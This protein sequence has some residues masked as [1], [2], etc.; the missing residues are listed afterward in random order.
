MD[1]EIART[2]VFAHTKWL[3]ASTW[4]TC[5]CD[6]CGLREFA[7][8]RV[9]HCKVEFRDADRSGMAASFMCIFAALFDIVLV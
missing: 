7:L 1:V 9:L 2:L 6:G 4:G 8:K 5:L 3:V